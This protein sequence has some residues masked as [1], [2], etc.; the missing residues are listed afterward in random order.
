MVSK[1]YPQLNIYFGLIS[2]FIFSSS[3]STLGVYAG[4]LSSK[5]NRKILLGVSMIL[6]SATSYFAGAVNSFFVFCLMRFLLGAFESACNPASYSLISDYFP[7]SYRSTANAIETAGS[8]VGGGLS[9]LCVILISM[10]G[11]RAMYM[12][13]GV[14]GIIM[15]LFTLVVLKEPKR[16]VYDFAKEF[17]PNK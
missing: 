17:Q 11:W 9:S 13:T 5:V 16:G 3:Y 15:G 1:S 7:V 10:Y 14:T 4:V 6:W 12:I 8:Y 2:S